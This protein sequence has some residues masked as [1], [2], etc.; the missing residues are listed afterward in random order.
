V[1]A[2]VKLND[3]D[4]KDPRTLRLEIEKSSGVRNAVIEY[5]TE[6]SAA[7]WH[8]EMSAALF[9]Y[10][11]RRN[12][13][14]YGDSKGVTPR[15]SSGV[16]ICVP[17]H[18]IESQDVQEFAGVGLIVTLR[19]NDDPTF[20]DA[21]NNTSGSLLYAA[22]TSPGGSSP[23]KAPSGRELRFLVFKHERSPDVPDAITMA[24]ERRRRHS[25][26]PPLE[27]DT[28]TVDFGPYASPPS[29][30]STNITD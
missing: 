9:N 20:Y 23:P 16:R 8:R 14:L 30:S 7:E 21:L 10:R 12:R 2:I 22:A 3:Y 18:R 4:P 24:K 13:A 26:E 11:Q 28:V 6:E 17:L 15:E 27:A 19:I 25:A 29:R 1:S 5:D